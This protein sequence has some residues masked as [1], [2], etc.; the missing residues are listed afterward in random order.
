MISFTDIN[1][2][3]KDNV[4]LDFESNT[5]YQNIIINGKSHFRNTQKND[6]II[7]E[8]SDGINNAKATSFSS[9]ILGID[10][11]TNPDIGAYQHIIFESGN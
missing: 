7:G 5:N 9:D 2:S 6:F 10:R 4:E 3:F 8:E 1:E 11:S